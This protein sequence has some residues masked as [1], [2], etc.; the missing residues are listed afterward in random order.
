MKIPN[1]IIVAIALIY[2]ALL[3][4]CE[5]TPALP[6]SQEITT[7]D[8]SYVPI[9]PS[10]TG[11]TVEVIGPDTL[12]PEDILIGNDQLLYVADTRANRVVMMNRAG[13]TLGS[14]EMLRP[15]SLAQN[16]RLDLYVG[17]EMQAPNGDIVGA[18]FKIRLYSPNSDSAHRI[19][20]APIDTIW[21]EL[22][23]PARRFPAITVFGDN[24]YLAVRTGPDNSSFID[25]DA[26]VL[27][28]N[29]ADAF[30]TP[31]PAFVTGVG[32]GIAYINKPTGIASFAGT[33]DFV[34]TQ[35]IDGVSYGAIWMR[36]EQTIDFEGW[37]PRYDP[38]RVEDRNIDFVRPRRYLQPEAVA[39]DRTRRDIFVADAELDSVF[40]FNSRGRFRNESFGFHQSQG[41]MRR[42]TGLAYF[43]RILYVLDGVTG[44]VMRFRL[45]TDIPR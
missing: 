43:E 5:S 16:T 13:Q 27:L 11:F 3:V 35:S 19:D 39:I 33:K 31:V 26:R 6:P 44:Q 25:P 12:G 2:I 4:G 15:Q 14:R 40:K 17:G 20:L 9:T 7:I 1:K 8:T 34:L 37:L 41:A 29:A 38:A 36:Y 45:S 24:Q 30:V 23:R 10:F 42:P 28:F 21:R 32:N 22:A 18:I